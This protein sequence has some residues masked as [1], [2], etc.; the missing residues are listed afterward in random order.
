MRV[1]TEAK[2]EAILEIAS[3]VFQEMGYERAS[4]DEIAA[5]LG[6]SKMTLYG[7][8]PSKQQLFLEVSHHMAMRHLGPAYDELVPGSDD[9]AGVL[10]RFAEKFLSFLC[11]PEAAGTYRMVMAQPVQSGIARSF[12]ELGPRRGEEQLAAF[13]RSEMEGGRLKPGDA[14]V[15]AMHF[16]ALTGAEVLQPV[17]MGAMAMPTRQRLRQMA[18]RAVTV[19]L[20]A[21]AA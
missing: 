10:R 8:F 16:L 5:R 14:S 17:L 9:L 3:Q 4:M 7:Y 20:A 15:A 18:D 13:V 1:K 11:T 21:Y 19:F 6:G 12:Y 2:R